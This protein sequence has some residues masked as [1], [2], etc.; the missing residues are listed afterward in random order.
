[1]CL[2][3]ECQLNCEADSVR[4]GRHFVANTL[5]GW[6]LEGDGPAAR[7]RDD[8]LLVASELLSNAVKACTRLIFLRIDG[9]RDHIDIAVGDDNP[10]PA[11]PKSAD[12]ESTG[13]RGLAIVGALSDTWGQLQHDG[14]SKRIWARIAVAPGAPIALACSH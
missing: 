12:L 1:M 9:H 11:A 14:T 3:V 6:G 13:G 5:A 2:R 4:A 10:T 8:V 7:T